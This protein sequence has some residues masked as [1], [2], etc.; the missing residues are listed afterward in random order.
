MLE[1]K[2]EIEKLYIISTQTK[3]HNKLFKNFNNLNEQ[4]IKKQ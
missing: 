2:K 4:N 1:I 3:R